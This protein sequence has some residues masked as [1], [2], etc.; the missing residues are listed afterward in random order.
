[1]AGRPEDVHVAAAIRQPCS[2]STAHAHRRRSA[3]ADHD[4]GLSDQ[5]GPRLVGVFNDFDQYAALPA[6]RHTRLRYVMVSH[7]N[8]S[9]S[10]SSVPTWSSTGPA[11]W[12]QD[13]N[14][15]GAGQVAG[16]Q[17]RSLTTFPADDDR[18]EERASRGGIGRSPD[19]RPDL[20][21]FVAR[22]SSA[23]LRRA[24]GANRD[25]KRR[26]HSFFLWA[27]HSA[28]RAATERDKA[29][30][31]WCDRRSPARWRQGSGNPLISRA[32]GRV[33]PHIV[34]LAHGAR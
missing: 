7:D 21:R 28:P 4:D 11:G 24:D 8:D 19:Y 31:C 17:W 5:F 1:M 30:S 2:D 6:E 14:R 18:H 22:S 29:V 9:V 25:R 3:A 20:A 15:Q 27:R 10:P 33:P 34:V 23:G 32:D 16:M 26:P 13:A 12:S